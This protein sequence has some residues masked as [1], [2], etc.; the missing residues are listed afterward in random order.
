M[1]S[2]KQLKKQ[3]RSKFKEGDRIIYEPVFWDRFTSKIED[4]S[5]GTIIKGDFGGIYADPMRKYILVDWDDG[6][7]E[8]VS[9]ESLKPINE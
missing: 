5:T 9:P 6:N 4:G 7:R 1:S 8:G 2:Y 3:A